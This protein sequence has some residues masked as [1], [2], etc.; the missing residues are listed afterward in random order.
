MDKLFAFV[1]RLI[2][3]PFY[4][5]ILF[6]H[7]FRIWVKYTVLYIKYGGAFVNFKAKTTQHGVQ[8]IYDLLVKKLDDSE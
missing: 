7:L 2:S 1:L 4:S 8:H 3:S 5:V 6:I